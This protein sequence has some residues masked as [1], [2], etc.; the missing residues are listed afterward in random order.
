MHHRRVHVNDSAAVTLTIMFNSL[1]QRVP[2]TGMTFHGR[3][4]C[5]RSALDSRVCRIIWKMPF[6]MKR[7]VHQ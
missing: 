1:P 6:K 4:A 5:Q 2:E 7:S 3:T